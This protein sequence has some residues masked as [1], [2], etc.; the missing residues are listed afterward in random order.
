ML[1]ET[2]SRT[3][4]LRGA[5]EAFRFCVNRAPVSEG[6]S[7]LFS[8]SV[9][10]IRGAFGA[11]PDALISVIFGDPKRRPSPSGFFI[12]SK[13]SEPPCLAEKRSRL[14]TDSAGLCAAWLCR[15]ILRVSSGDLSIGDL[16][17]ARVVQAVV[18]PFQL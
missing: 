18:G 13:N 1:I 17:E 4:T 10:E 8:G 9:S 3:E 5:L 15:W 6:D 7:I 11:L 12:P 16:V 2:K 14:T